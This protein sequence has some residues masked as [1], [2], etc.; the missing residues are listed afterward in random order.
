MPSKPFSLWAPKEQTK[1]WQNSKYGFKLLNI[2]INIYLFLYY[3]DA[4][5]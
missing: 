3:G 5:Q 1:P 2:T 4:K